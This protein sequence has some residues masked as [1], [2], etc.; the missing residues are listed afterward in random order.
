MV[1]IVK[2]CEVYV[3]KS[4]LHEVEACLAMFHQDA[5]YGSTTVGGHQGIEAITTMM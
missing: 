4:N 1:D 3:N 5:V 2:A